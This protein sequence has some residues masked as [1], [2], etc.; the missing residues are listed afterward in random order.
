MRLIELDELGE[1]ANSETREVV[2]LSSARSQTVRRRS[3][4]SNAML[5]SFTQSSLSPSTLAAQLM[6]KT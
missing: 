4:G 2:A 6:V 3:S 5:I 1:I